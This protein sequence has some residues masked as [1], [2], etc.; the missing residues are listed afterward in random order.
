[1]LQGKGIP[2]HGGEDDVAVGAHAGRRKGDREAV[3][4]DSLGGHLPVAAQLFRGVLQ[5]AGVLAYGRHDGVAVAAQPLGGK[6]QGTPLVQDCGLDNLAIGL[7]VVGRPLQSETV[8]LHGRHD[9]LAVGTES[10]VGVDQ[11][12]QSVLP[13]GRRCCLPLGGRALP[14][15]CHVCRVNAGN[16]HLD[17]LVIAPD[18]ALHGG[19]AVVLPA[20]REGVDRSDGL[21]PVVVLGCAH[22]EGVVLVDAEPDSI[23][24]ALVEHHHR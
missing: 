19:N 9:N 7:E 2:L 1:M 22:L 8:L 4:P 18:A 15:G 23:L 24:S 20:L 21:N 17:N 11:L 16:R 12:C 13:L 10:T 5:G 3:V 14:A 6:L